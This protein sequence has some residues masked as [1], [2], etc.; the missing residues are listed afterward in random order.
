M[1]LRGLKNGKSPG[2]SGLR[3]EYLKVWLADDLARDNILRPFLTAICNGAVSE[4]VAAI[5]GDSDLI[6]LD[7]DEEGGIRPVALLE[8]IRTLAGRMVLAKELGNLRKAL[9]PFQLAVGIKGGIE[10]CVHAV[11]GIL[12]KLPDWVLMEVDFE[13]MF[14]E[15]SRNGLLRE[16]KD[17]CPSALP[18]VRQF[19]ARTANVSLKVSKDDIIEFFLQLEQGVFQGDSWGSA[20]ACLL[21]LSFQKELK[22]RLADLGHEMVQLAIADDLHCLGDPAAITDAYKIIRQLAPPKDS[23]ET[24]PE[25]WALKLKPPKVKLYST[26]GIEYLDWAIP[27]DS[28]PA[29]VERC[30][31][32][33]RVVGAPV[34]TDDFCVSYCNDQ[35]EKWK[36]RAEAIA[37]Y[38]D[39]QGANLMLRHTHISRCAFL[40]RS[41][42]P[43]LLKEAAKKMDALTRKSL[44]Q[45]LGTSDDPD[46]SL[47]DADWAQA[48]LSIKHG[49]LGYWGMERTSPAAYAGSLGL[50]LADLVTLE[51]SWPSCLKGLFSDIENQVDIPSCVSLCEALEVA[52]A[53]EAKG[54][55]DNK[56]LQQYTH[57]KTKAESAAAKQAKPGKKAKG[58]GRTRRQDTI[59]SWP[60]NAEGAYARGF[61]PPPVENDPEESKKAEFPPLADL[62]EGKVYGL[63]RRVSGWWAAS[64]QPRLLRSTADDRTKARL[65][66]VSGCGSGAFLTCI[67]VDA[68]YTLSRQQMLTGMRYRLGLP[69]PGARQLQGRRCLCGS[70]AADGED[71]TGEHILSCQ[72]VGS[73]F[74]GQ[75]GTP[76]EL[77]TRGIFVDAGYA[78]ARQVVVGSEEEKTD[79][80][81]FN[82]PVFGCFDLPD[83][84][85]GENTNFATTELHIDNT[86]VAA[87]CDAALARGS[88][89][90]RGA[91]A[92]HAAMQKIKKY[93]DKVP[94]FSPG[95]VETHGYIN[96]EFKKLLHHTAECHIYQSAMDAGLAAGERKL[97]KGF[98]INGYYQRISVA[99]VKGVATAL[100]LATSAVLGHASKPSKAPKLTVA[101]VHDIIGKQQAWQRGGLAEFDG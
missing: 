97:L 86:V 78:T 76:L 68:R 10:V 27:P 70:L 39:T 85:A 40:N 3:Y 51:E 14:N 92:H 95:A 21:L 43:H 72:H 49:G 59:E 82:F 45:I 2:G 48:Q 80:T 66:S 20:L 53:I 100:R 63:Q 33:V 24:A 71:M 79:V 19:Y 83:K 29:E 5:M 60:A 88:S 94:S 89:R 9:L 69:M 62:K 38:P 44:N 84:D 55:E 73:K 28:I 50:C 96:A 8:A 11:R 47:D 90:K 91:Y 30:A 12:E 54:R 101:R 99:V 81:V 36:Q 61:G 16:C 18:Y 93:A 23:G 75:R 58:K 52:Q 31:D 77:C 65:L 25:P 67:P 13:N 37:E 26:R 98:I 32:G 35:V 15:I 6:L 1:A 22:K 4:E 57:W 46:W 42:P 17:Y 87:C 74:H 41:T 56:C 34:G 7:K 64:E